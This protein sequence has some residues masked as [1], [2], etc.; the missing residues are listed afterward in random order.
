MLIDPEG[1]PL[2][3]QSRTRAVIIDAAYEPLQG[4]I[5]LC[6]MLPNRDRRSIVLSKD[7]FLFHGEDYRS[8]PK[9]ETD[10][11]MEKTTALFR[12][13]KGRSINLDAYAQQLEQVK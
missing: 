1:N 5:I 10:R 6:V 8:L 3:S 12:A 4:Q 11:E 9:E 13:A 2:A 7:N